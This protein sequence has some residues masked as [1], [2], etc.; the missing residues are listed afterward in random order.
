[1]IDVGCTQFD[2]P[3]TRPSAVNF[4]ADPVNAKLQGMKLSFNVAG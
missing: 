1:M 3:A 4:Y 2:F